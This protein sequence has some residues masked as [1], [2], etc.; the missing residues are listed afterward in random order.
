MFDENKNCPS[1]IHYRGVY[2]DPSLVWGPDS[3]AI[4]YDHLVLDS[5]SVA[6]FAAATLTVYLMENSF[7][8]TLPVWSW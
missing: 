3:K 5:W 4:A 6:Y 1:Y 8:L 7:A 2:L